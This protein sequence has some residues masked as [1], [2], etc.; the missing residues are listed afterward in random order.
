VRHR[1]R[2]WILVSA[3]REESDRLADDG[4]VR[5]YLA[6]ASATGGRVRFVEGNRRR[7][8]VASRLAG[9]HVRQAWRAA[10][11]IHDGDRVFAD[12][13]HNGIPLALFLRLRGR[14]PRSLVM[15]G[16][17]L[18]SPWKRR[19]LW[20]ASRVGTPAT[21]LVHSVVQLRVAHGTLG[22]GWKAAITPFHVDTRFWQPAGDDRVEGP[23]AVVAA[24]SE[25]RDYD[26]LVA[27]AART[28]AV[29]VVIAAGSHW[30]RRAATAGE[31]PLPPNVEFVSETLSFARLRDLY[32]RAAAVVVPLHDVENQS[33][34]T[35]ILEGM[36]MG[37][38]AVVTATRGQRE[39]V[40]GP[41]VSAGGA[42]DWGATA[43]RGPHLFGMGTQDRRASTGVYVEP[44][45]VDAL[46]AALAMAAAGTLPVLPGP[47]IRAFAQR[48]F[49][50]EAFVER[51]AGAL[52][53]G[54]LPSPRAADQ[55]SR[56]PGDDG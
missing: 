32:A 13:E 47:G 20:L 36:S 35:T 50:T 27:A 16:H 19:A 23:P 1:A 29:Q 51:I 34:V 9:A 12:G 8:G 21:V 5:D 40:S 37:L 43:G 49:D 54:A 30:A 46:A 39:C 7:E 15:L 48:W 18:S 11:L 10:A 41:L 28:P 14:R 2:T 26:T 3:T 53:T 56:C 22:R 44:G 52:T 55:E 33:G 31:G 6:L 38:P 25:N 17:L 24:G 42:L 45:D 4:P